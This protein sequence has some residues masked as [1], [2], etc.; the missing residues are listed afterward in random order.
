MSRAKQE[1]PWGHMEWLASSEIGNTTTL[2]V[3]RMRVRP[4]GI[5][6]RHRHPNC[7]EVVVVQKGVLSLDLDGT[8]TRYAAGGFVVVPAG[9]AHRI[10]NGESDELL[11]LLSYGAGTRIYEP[12]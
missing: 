4:Q 6:E 3:A 5:S 12:C 11:L 7:D 8:T 10:E 2:S 1:F 9:C